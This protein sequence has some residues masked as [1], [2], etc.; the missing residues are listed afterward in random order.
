MPDIVVA[1]QRI[2]LGPCAVT[3]CRNGG[4]VAV[5]LVEGVVVYTCGNCAEKIRGGQFQPRGTDGKES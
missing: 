5:E 2:A 4:M 1:V 3:D